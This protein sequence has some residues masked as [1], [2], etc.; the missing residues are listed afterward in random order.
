[1]AKCKTGYDTPEKAIAW[2]TLYRGWK[3]MGG[4]VAQSAKQANEGNEPK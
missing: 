4:T 1:L 3:D 2:M